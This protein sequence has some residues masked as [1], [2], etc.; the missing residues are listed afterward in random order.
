MGT[1]LHEKE[2]GFIQ[3][4]APAE[5]AADPGGAPAATAGAASTEVPG[6]RAEA[7]PRGWLH[8]TSM[9]A[10]VP[11][12]VAT[13]LLAVLLSVARSHRARLDALEVR[14]E[15]AETDEGTSVPGPAPTARR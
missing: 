10:L 1:P 15:Q 4:F 14:F 6:T 3:R 8:R 13:A 11:I 12:L 5:H 7:A 2:T 9:T